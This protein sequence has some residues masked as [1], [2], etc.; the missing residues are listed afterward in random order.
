M[1]QYLTKQCVTKTNCILTVAMGV[2]IFKRDISRRLAGGDQQHAS[3]LSLLIV[4]FF[5][6]V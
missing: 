5:L 1:L 6:K 3:Y 4:F 2:L